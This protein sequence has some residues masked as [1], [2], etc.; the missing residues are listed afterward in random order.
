MVFFVSDLHYDHDPPPA[1]P[2]LTGGDE[3]E[4]ELVACLEYHRQHLTHVVLLGDLFDA[5]IEYRDLVPK[6]LTRLFGLLAL[7][8]DQGLSVTVVAGNH[9]PWHRDYMERHLGFRVLHAPFVENLG[10]ARV[11]F[12]HGDQGPGLSRW[13]RFIRSRIVHTLYAEL[14]P[15]SFGLWL[16]R[17]WSR[18][19]RSSRLDLKQVVRLRDR[20][21]ALLSAG[22][23]E[24]V[25]YGHC[26]TAEQHA[27]DDGTYLNTGSWA[28][29]RT[30]VTVDHGTARL[31]SWTGDGPALAHQ[32]S[33]PTKL[34]AV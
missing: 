23:A 16:A 21:V 17:M 31:W 13:Q 18:G 32:D 8:A 2:L 25:V 5:W 1:D 27:T 24:V 29:S 30:F 28:L 4:R 19:A 20:A 33:S 12:G 6:G 10:G 14:L 34:V 11:S 15:G 3:A 9:D 22:T 7:W 26:H